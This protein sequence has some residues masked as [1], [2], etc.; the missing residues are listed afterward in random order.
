MTLAA[1]WPPLHP[2]ACQGCRCIHT[3]PDCGPTPDGGRRCGC[4][5][6]TRPG[7]PCTIPLDR[8]PLPEYPPL[9]LA[10]HTPAEAAPAPAKPRA[11]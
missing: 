2:D 9:Q 3:G 10:R 11:R 4:W 5:G 7:C 1:H 8:T 6:C